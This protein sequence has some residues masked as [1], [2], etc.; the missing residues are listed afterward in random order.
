M[1]KKT[2]NTEM[3]MPSNDPTTPSAA[4]LRQDA[5]L[6]TADA[7]LLS[8]GNSSHYARALRRAAAVLDAEAARLEAADKRCEWK[9]ND[10][11]IGYE[12]SCHNRIVNGVPVFCGECGSR[13]RLTTEGVE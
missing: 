5:A 2:L 6:L 10:V 12:T 3:S 8:A 11:H 13:V 4:Q 1:M 9:W 7:E